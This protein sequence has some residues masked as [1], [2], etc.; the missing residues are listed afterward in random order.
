MISYYLSPLTHHLHI[1]SPHI[2]IDSLLVHTDKMIKWL[3][4]TFVKLYHTT[5]SHKH[6]L[7]IF[8]PHI[9]NDTL[10]I[11]KTK[12]IIC[13]LSLSIKWFHTTCSHK[14]ICYISLV[15]ILY[16]MI[17]L[18]STKQNDNMPFIHIYRRIPSYL[19]TQTH[20][21]PI[22]SPHIQND[23]LGIHK[24]EYNMP[25]IHIYKMIPYY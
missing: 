22:F 25:S 20:H 2:Q 9:H 21:L 16:K 18:L 13:L 14:H 6:M 10:I 17:C 5:F 23:T 24:T 7:H 19:F 15:H 12:V 8:S 11:H 1:F 4:S 3:S